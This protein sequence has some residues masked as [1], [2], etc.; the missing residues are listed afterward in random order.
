MQQVLRENLILIGTQEFIVSNSIWHPPIAALPL[1]NMS[2]LGVFEEWA[3]SS[4][5]IPTKQLKNRTLVITVYS[6][7]LNESTVRQF[8]IVTVSI[9]SG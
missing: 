5:E 1:L 9:L 2:I 8:Y 4:P 6:F 3:A 7:M